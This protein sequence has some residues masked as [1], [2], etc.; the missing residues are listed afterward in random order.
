MW[1]KF[2]LQVISWRHED[3]LLLW[4]EIHDEDDMSAV[5]KIQA[6]VNVNMF[7]ILFLFFVLFGLYNSTSGVALK[8]FVILCVIFLK[9]H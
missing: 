5:E 9:S 1:N 3:P 4:T 2:L 6:Q 8:Q 7:G